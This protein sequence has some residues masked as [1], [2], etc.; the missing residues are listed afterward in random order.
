VTLLAV[1]VAAALSAA[2]LPIVES[3]APSLGRAR[4]A[5]VSPLAGA[6]AAVLVWSADRVE[7]LGLPMAIGLGGVAVVLAVQVILDLSTHRLPRQISHLGLALFV[8]AAVVGG[9]V[10]RVPSA[11]VGMLAMTAVTGLLVMV[12]RG[13]LGIGDLHLAPLLGA[14]VGWFSPAL[15][16]PMWIVTA[17]SGG[18]VVAVGLAA[19]RLDRSDH[20]PY[21]P[22]MVFGSMVA[23][24]IGAVAVR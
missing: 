18:V 17:L 13:S 23:V 21:G 2:A 5:L 7:E 8:V 12:T 20:V 9:D 22:F 14:L 1:C 24:L 11:L 10:A 3:M 16:V 4:A 19:G 15:I 6:L